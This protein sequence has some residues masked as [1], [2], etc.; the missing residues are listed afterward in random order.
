M[1]RLNAPILCNQR[2]RCLL[3]NS[4]NTRD[5][6][7]GIAHKCLDIDKFFWCDQITFL[8]IFCK[9]IFNFSSSLFC[10]RNTDFYMFRCKLQQV[11]VSGYHRNIHAFPLPHSG[12]CS[13]QIIR[14]VT[15]HLDNT[16]AHGSQHLFDHR[17]LL[18]Q[19]II[20]R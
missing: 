10:L 4:R 5:I 15:F 16:Y 14:F 2:C 12:K 11:A 6:V 9:I 7:R 1:Y 18:P 8:N 20:H 3:S 17:H 13:K 19:G